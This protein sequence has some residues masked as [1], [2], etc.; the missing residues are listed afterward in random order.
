[1][2]TCWRS[3]RTRSRRRLLLAPRPAHPALK[4]RT[5]SSNAYLPTTRHDIAVPRAPSPRASTPPVRAVAGT[6]IN[7]SR[8]A[9]TGGSV[10]SSPGHHARRR[11]PPQGHHREPRTT[12]AAMP[13][14]EA[15]DARTDAF[16]VSCW[17]F[18]PGRAGVA[19]LTSQIEAASSRTRGFGFW[20][21]RHP[22]EP[23]VPPR[24]SPFATWFARRLIV[25]GSRK[26]DE[27]AVV[28]RIPDTF[29]LARCRHCVRPRSATATPHHPRRVRW[30][31]HARPARVLLAEAPGVRRRPDPS[32]LRA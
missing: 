15:S 31:H 29:D 25:D 3:G 32:T 22:P 23:G 21:R 4:G 11:Q 13:G 19:E 24:P 27:Q 20:P 6:S 2:R 14:P 1:M 12:M 26:P 17:P 8:V 5:S 28:A 10:S 30:R 18:R 16:F 7:S 9:Q